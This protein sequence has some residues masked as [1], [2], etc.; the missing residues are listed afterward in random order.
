MSLFLILYLNLEYFCL[1]TYFPQS[2]LLQSLLLLS[3]LF[4]FFISIPIVPISDL[5]ISILDKFKPYKI[6]RGHSPLLRTLPPSLDT[7]WQ[8]PTTLNTNRHPTPH[9]NCLEAEDN[10]KTFKY[11]INEYNSLD[12]GCFL[13][14]FYSI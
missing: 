4:F 2:L 13:Y 10:G 9:E 5:D 6:E 8:P 1:A 11:L 7:H 3:R 14:H 12:L